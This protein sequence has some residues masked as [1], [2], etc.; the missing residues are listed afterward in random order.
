MT[1]I[2]VKRRCEGAGE[3]RVG[4]LEVGKRESGKE[5]KRETGKEGERNWR[6]RRGKGEKFG[7]KGKLMEE[8]EGQKGG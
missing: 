4:E 1:I 7:G 8:E 3:K 5:E 6:R 2:T